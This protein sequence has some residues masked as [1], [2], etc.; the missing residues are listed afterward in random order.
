MKTGDTF[1]VK[2]REHDHL[3]LAGIYIDK[4]T[5]CFAIHQRPYLERINLLPS[6]EN[7]ISFRRARSQLLWLTLSRSDVC[8][9]ANKLAQVTEKTFSS[10]QVKQFNNALKRLQASKNLALHMKKLD[11][12]SL[13]IKAF[14]DAS[15]S[16]NYDQTSQ[17][18]Y[19]ITLCDKFNNACI[20]HYASYKSRRVAKSVLGAESYAFADAYNLGYCL[21]KELE[22]M[23]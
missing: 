13:H 23:L 18:G 9:D 12:Q 22:L 5:N 10:T 3:R 19:I 4:R 17:L 11:F 14:S 16:T 20:L 7:F 1:E 6:D 21:K 15:F 8:V 2:K